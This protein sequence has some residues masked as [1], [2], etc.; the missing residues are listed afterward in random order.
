MK[1]KRFR[2][3]TNGSLFKVQV[4]KRVLSLRGWKYVWK[5]CYQEDS[6]WPMESNWTPFF[7]SKEKA[8][9]FIETQKKLVCPPYTQAGP[10]IE[11]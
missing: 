5:D 4:R 6:S 1:T 7:P 8:L 3:V 9:E 11:V 2:I 10:E